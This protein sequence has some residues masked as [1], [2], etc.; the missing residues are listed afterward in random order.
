VGVGVAGKRIA[1]PVGGIDGVDHRR[2]VGEHALS[3]RP[4]ISLP[5]Q[6]GGIRAPALQILGADAPR[7]RQLPRRPSAA[8]SSSRSHS[9]RIACSSR[10]G[11]S[12][13]GSRSGQVRRRLRRTVE[14][15]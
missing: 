9:P 10:D 14:H 4:W 7:R 8:I 13:A 1:D 15:P 12:Q 11:C 3:E 6:P 5:R 2:E